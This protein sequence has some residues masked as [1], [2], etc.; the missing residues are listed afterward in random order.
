MSGE[1]TVCLR[2][3]AVV[4][5]RLTLTLSLFCASVSAAQTAASLSQIKKIYVG[6]LGEKKGSSELREALVKRL[7][8]VRGVEVVSTQAGADA[9]ISGSGEIWIKGYY[10]TGARPSPYAQNAIYGGVLSI[11]VKG[12]DA[13][14][15]WS[16]L[17]TPRKFH[18]GT[19]TQDLADNLVKKFQEAVQDSA[20]KGASH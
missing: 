20:A 5:L 15:L 8:D 1:W 13:E 17:V 14:T 12:K 6:S 9:V 3:I 2:G 16:Y 19:V 18:W 11:E 4:L 10:S 7:R